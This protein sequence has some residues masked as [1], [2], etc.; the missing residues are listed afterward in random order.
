MGHVF[1]VICVPTLTR[2]IIADLRSTPKRSQRST[3]EQRV[4][5]LARR[6]S[7]MH[8]T[9]PITYRKLVLE[10]LYGNHVPMDGR[11][12]V[13]MS[14]R[15]V[16]S[17]PDQ[18]KFIYDATLEQELWRRWARGEFSVSDQEKAHLWR[19]EIDTIDIARFNAGWV[20]FTKRFIGRVPAS[21]RPWSAPTN[22]SAAATPS[23][24]PRS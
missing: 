7:S 9:T 21:R 4:Q 22:S 8:L 6:M 16:I 23:D 2:E 5:D 12:P 15:N 19:D 1:D 3:A 18:R 17:S 24:C 11:I 13:D 14:A 20:A 10:S